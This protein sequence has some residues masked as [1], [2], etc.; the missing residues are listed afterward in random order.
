MLEGQVLDPSGATVAAASVRAANRQTGFSRTQLTGP[1][2]GFSLALPAG[3]YDLSVS[4]PNLAAFQREAISLHVSRTVRV[5]VQLQLEGKTT[6]VNVIAAADLLDIGSNAIGNV[7]TGRELIDL[8]LNGRNFTQLGLL[9]PG[10]APMTAGL[11]QAGGS[12]RSGQ[13]Y[14]VNGQRPETNNY[15]L[16]GVSNALPAGGSRLHPENDGEVTPT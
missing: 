4:A 13:A 3:E 1:S 7:V 16:D 14:A 11:A 10:V 5:D 9:Q 15:L 6:T 8:P 2:G 12:L